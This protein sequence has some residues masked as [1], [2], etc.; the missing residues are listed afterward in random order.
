MSCYKAK[1]H[2]I[3]RKFSNDCVQIYNLASVKGKE[4]YAENLKRFRNSLEY[5]QYSSANGDKLQ[6]ELTS[7]EVLCAAKIICARKIWLLFL[8]D[9]QKAQAKEN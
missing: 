4:I 2:D 6:M 7:I 3:Y 1:C 5:R 8:V 9:M